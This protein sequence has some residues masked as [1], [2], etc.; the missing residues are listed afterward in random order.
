M[1]YI[2]HLT[3]DSNNTLHEQS[4]QDHLEGTAQFARQF[5]QTF[6]YGEWAYCCGKLHDIGKYSEKFQKRIRGNTEKVDH[7]TAGAQLC[8]K[9]GGYYN[10]LAYCIAG[11][12]AGLPDTGGSSDTGDSKTLEGRVKKKVE[13]Y[14]AFHGEISIPNLEQSFFLTTSK[15]DPSFTVSFFIRMMYSCLVDA[16][17]LDTERFMQQGE[18]HRKSGEEIKTLWKKF[19]KYVSK[20]LDCKERDTINGRRSEILSHCIYMGKENPGLFRLTVPTG[21]GKTAASLGFALQHAVEHGLSR[22]IYVIPYTSIIE[23]NASVFS[24]ILGRENVLEH[25]CNVNYDGNEELKPMQ[26]ATENWD[27]PVIVTTNV[28]FFESLFANK[29]SKCRKL[30]NLANSVIIFDEVQMLPNDYL[31]PCIA[32]MEEL[33]RYYGSSVVLCTATQPALQNIMSK[34]MISREL[35]PRMEEQFSFF[36]RSRIID[37][38]IILEETLI[39]R[40]QHE[41][42]ALC[43]CNTKKR[44]SELYEDMSG[45]GVFHLSTTMYPLHRK[46]ILKEIKKRLILKERCIVI[47]TSL[48]EAGVDLDF[49]VVYREMA[50]IDSVIQAAGRC[51]REGLRTLE[52]SCTYIFQFEEQRRIP[53]QEQQI[54]TGKQ[55]F[56]IYED[57]TDLKAI[58]EYFLRLYRYRGESLDKKN[59][60][61]QFQ[62]GSFP[63]AKVSREFQII[64]ENTKTIFIPTE[65]RAGEIVKELKYKGATRILMREAGQYCVSVYE[66]MFDKMNG[67]GML[68]PLS[69]E[70]KEEMFV[71]KNSNDYSEEKGLNLTVMEGCGI[72]L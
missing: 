23:Q 21:G 29:P 2:A 42:Q 52:E 68:S 59:I 26:L 28:Q 13:D 67:A 32:G 45:E 31:K 48:I 1:N 3:K 61:G 62:K 36:K 18:T 69:E 17:F 38:G 49:Q 22:I 64:E 66:T 15:T 39:Q 55:V 40:L 53:G 9:L 57:I 24:E 11:H 47:A 37:I 27:K 34:D 70:L 41:Y 12:H 33:V 63:F 46:R 6:G 35:C 43:I 14:Q 5:G 20:W 25:H 58:H 7:A 65:E 50:G 4:L 56:R 71:L 16:D 60:L 72:W 30:H 54:D 10:W 8:R 19:E 51:N 44:V